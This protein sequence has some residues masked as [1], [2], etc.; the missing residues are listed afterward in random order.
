MI[1]SPLTTLTLPTAKLA[2]T[3]QWLMEQNLTQPKDYSLL[4]VD[5][6]Q[7][8]VACTSAEVYANLQAHTA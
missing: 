2:S 5:D 4:P 1:N 8:Q 6:D 7:F 3:V